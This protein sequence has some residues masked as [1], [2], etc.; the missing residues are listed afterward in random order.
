MYFLNAL[1]QILQSFLRKTLGRDLNLLYTQERNI[2][3]FFC[4]I[5]YDKTFLILA[6]DVKCMYPACLVT[7]QCVFL[8]MTRGLMRDIS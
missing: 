3:S 1:Q 5:T 7:H 6:M 2:S 8:Q 4:L